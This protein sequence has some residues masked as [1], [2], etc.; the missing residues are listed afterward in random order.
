M[1]KKKSIKAFGKAVILAAEK[2]SL[3]AYTK[4]LRNHAKNLGWPEEVYSSLSV[5]HDGI[6]PHIAY[7]ED[8]KDLV[9]DLEYGTLDSRPSPALRTVMLG[10]R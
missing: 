6:S 4:E 7:S 5:K 10:G 3:E 9:N 2:R 1:A 8:K